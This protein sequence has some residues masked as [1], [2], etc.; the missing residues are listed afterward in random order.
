MAKMNET[1][2]GERVRIAV[3][4]K[5]NAGK[6]TLVN[7]L[8]GQ[9]VGIVSPIA[10]TT[11]DPISKAM[12][13][14]PLGPVTITDTAGL[15]DTTALGPERMRRTMDILNLTDIAIIVS[16]DG[17]F[18]ER[19]CELEEMCR[20]RATPC[21]RYSRGDSVEELKKKLAEIKVAD[22]PRKVIGDMVSAGDIVI[23]V[24]PIDESAPKGRLILP[25]QQVVRELLDAHASAIVCQVNELAAILKKVTPRMV[26]TDSQAFKTVRAIVPEDIALTGFSVLFARAKGDLEEYQRGLAKLRTLP[27]GARV[28]IAEGCTHHLQCNDIGH[29]QLPNA[30][31]RLVGCTL[32]FDWVGGNDF[33]HE[34]GGYAL[35]VHCGGCM[36]TRRAVQSRIHAA[37]EAGVPI[38]NYGL[39]FQALSEQ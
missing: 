27:A 29:K 33:P 35:I 13:L 26:V 8:T 23:C 11:T 19:E 4:G 7:A 34:L 25:Q 18:G 1:A 5:V 37:R 39:I 24:C 10:G 32:V 3:F 28:L 12:E 14:L 17:T 30:I 38:T 15:D 16:A 20:K 2:S 22:A 36:L 31:Q 9:Q 21:L 6:T